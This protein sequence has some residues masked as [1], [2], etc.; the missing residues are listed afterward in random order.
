MTI[1]YLSINGNFLSMNTRNQELGFWS[2]TL[3]GIYR[4][5]QKV[6]ISIKI[7]STGLKLLSVS[8]FKILVINLGTPLSVQVPVVIC[9]V[10]MSGEA[11]QKFV[12]CE[13]DKLFSWRTL[14]LC[15]IIRIRTF[16]FV[17]DIFLLVIFPQISSLLFYIYA[18]KKKE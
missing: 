11:I 8:M 12:R 4:E 2:R 17:F 15:Y 1:T 16:F 3:I 6:Q 14:L 18:Q 10:V 5:H 7:F 9:D 13:K